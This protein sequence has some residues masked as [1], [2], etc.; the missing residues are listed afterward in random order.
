FLGSQHGVYYKFPTKE[1]Y[2]VY[3]LKDKA[4][5]LLAQ[6]SAAQIDLS[7]FIKVAD[8]SVS[9]IKG[10]QTLL[11]VPKNQRVSVF[12]V[13]GNEGV[14]GALLATTTIGNVSKYRYPIEAT[15]FDNR[16]DYTYAPSNFRNVSALSKQFFLIENIEN[17]VGVVW[18]DKNNSDLKLT[19]MGADFITHQALTLPNT[20]KEDLAAVTYDE[21]GNIYY[22]T[23]QSGSGTPNEIARSATLYQVD[24]QGNQQNRKELTTTKSGLNIINFSSSNV[25]SLQYLNGQLGLILAR[26]M[27]KSSDGLNHQG[28]IAVIFDAKSLAM[29]KHLGQTSGHS[30]DNIVLTHNSQNEFLGVDLGDNFPRGINVHKFTEQQRRSRVVYT[31]KTKHGTQA[32]S[33]AGVSY[34]FYSEISQGTNYY[35]W[36]NDNN[37]YTELAGMVENDLGYGVLFAGEPFNNKAIDNSRVG[38]T[39]NDP[40]NIGMV[41]VRKDFEKASGSGNEVSDDLILT[42]G[43]TEEGGLYTFGGSWA[44]QRNKGVVWLTNYKD[45]TQENATRVKVVAIDDDKMIILWEK[46]T[47]TAYI[48]TYA[49]KVDSEGKALSDPLALGSM[50]RLNRTDDIFFKDKKIYVVMGNKNEKKLELVVFDLK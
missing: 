4:I 19:W 47:D 6:V 17:Q 5:N 11:F 1:D 41:L 8:L 28:A 42:S 23:I 48:N 35:K 39:L 2:S 18:Q 49:M 43:I 20:R 34:P 44:A 33:P 45:K 12:N 46:W 29:V 26:K 9:K 30:L 37:T 22:L 16:L 3:E 15:I 32:K 14:D 27:H 10:T 13:L 31:F 24:S 21:N 40:R 50:V 38:K 36:S 25:A 7:Q